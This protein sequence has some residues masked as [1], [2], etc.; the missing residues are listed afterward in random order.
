MN[1]RSTNQSGWTLLELMV[2]IVIIGLFASILLVN[3]TVARNKARDANRIEEIQQVQKV[4][5]I[6]F[7]SYGKYP[8]GDGDGC[9]NWDIGNTTYP[10]LNVP[11]MNTFFGNGPAPVDTW[12]TSNCDGFMY[13]RY[14]PGS[15]GCP[16][17]RG[18]FYVLGIPDTQSTGNPYPGSPGWSC[19][20]RDWQTEFDWVTGSFEH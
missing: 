17:S 15:Y 16:V 13:Y 14:P 6:Y 3:L 11:G 7:L 2:V 5:E 8:D 18:A 19:P 1:T 9:G 12:Q 10:F 20:G 4:L